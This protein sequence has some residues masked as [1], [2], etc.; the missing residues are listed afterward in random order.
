MA[1]ISDVLDCAVVDADG[2]RLGKVRDVRLV[3]D[4]P[5]DGALA[6]L[7]LD[8]VIVG[9]GAFA[10]RLGYLRGGVRGP[11]MLKAVMSRLE[12]RAATYTCG[13]IGEWDLTNRRLHLIP[14]AHAEDDPDA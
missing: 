1:R 6:R 4:G 8:A 10:G 7:R 11:A 5:V 9:G 3:M 14:G 2:R 12:R 13:E